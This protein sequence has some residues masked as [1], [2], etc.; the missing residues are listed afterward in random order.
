MN[1]IE[2][3]NRRIRHVIAQSK[4]PED[5]L[6]AEN[7]LMWLL[8]LNPHADEALRIAALGHDIERALEERRL[9]KKD[10]TDFEE[11]KAAHARNSADIL[12]DIMNECNVP[13]AL[14]T[15]IWRLVVHHE[16]GGDLRSDLL[17]DADSLSFF[18]VNLPFYYER[19]GREE[20]IRRS[21][22]GYRRI[23]SDNRH[24]TAGITYEDDCLTCLLHDII[25]MASREQ[26]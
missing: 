18:H 3:M 21:L 19:R 7:T 2:C 23:S 20:T 24:F 16:T 22:W 9:R 25:R 17:K 11:F 10:F 12:R 13:E 4:V 8:K 5:P 6:H 14:A 1:Y 26:R 15:E